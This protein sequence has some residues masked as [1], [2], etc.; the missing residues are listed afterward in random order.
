MELFFWPLVFQSCLF[1]RY[2]KVNLSASDPAIHHHHPI[3]VSA[4]CQTVFTEMNNIA[5]QTTWQ[6]VLNIV[7][8]F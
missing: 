6:C 2:C 3:N 1:E 8:G 4:T 5:S 7:M